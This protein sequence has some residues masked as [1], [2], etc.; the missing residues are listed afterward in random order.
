[1][2]QSAG[3]SLE[4]PTGSSYEAWHPV[5]YETNVRVRVIYE[6]C[7]ALGLPMVCGRYGVV[8]GEW[9]PGSRAGRAG[10]RQGARSTCGG[11]CAFGYIRGDSARLPFALGAQNWLTWLTGVQTD[12][13]G[14]CCPP[15]ARCGWALG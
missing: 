13:C 1:M 2:D 5:I 11:E 10:A 15:R 14:P 4:G 9:D 3:G 12:R 6:T 8:P 7:Q